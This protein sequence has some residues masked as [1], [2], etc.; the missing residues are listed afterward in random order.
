[1]TPPPILMLTGQMRVKGLAAMGRFGR[2]FLEPRPD[3]RIES[4]VGV[5]P[6]R[7]VPS[8]LARAATNILGAVAFPRPGVRA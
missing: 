1:M 5:P 3:Q 6:G 8:F 4:E 7:G 2:L